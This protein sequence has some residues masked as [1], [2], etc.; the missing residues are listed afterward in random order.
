MNRMLFLTVMMFFVVGIKDILAQADNCNCNSDEICIGSCVI[1][2]AEGY[3]CSRCMK[4]TSAGKKITVG[5]AGA[6]VQ[7]S[8][9]AITTTVQDS[10]RRLQ[11][12]IAQATR[13]NNAT[14]GTIAKFKHDY[15]EG[16][17][18]WKSARYVGGGN[19]LPGLCRIGLLM[20]FIL[21]VMQLMLDF[22]TMVLGQ[23]TH[24][25]KILQKNLAKVLLLAILL[26]PPIYTAIVNLVASVSDSIANSIQSAAHENL[27]KDI[28]A[29]A[30]AMVADKGVSFWKMAES[31]VTY[32]ISGTVFILNLVL[33]MVFPLLQSLIFALAFYLGP[34]CLP[35]MM[36]D[37][38]SNIAKSWFSFLLTVSFMSVI[39]SL[40]ILV[41]QSANLAGAAATG[42]Q[43][44][45]VIAMIIY[46]GLSVVLLLMCYPISTAIFGAGGGGG[47]VGGIMSGSAL[48]TGA[49]VAFTGGAALAARGGGAATTLAGKAASGLGASGLGSALQK[50]G[51]AMS[52]Y[53]QGATNAFVNEMKKS[54][55]RGDPKGPSA[56]DLANPLNVPLWGGKPTTPGNQGSSGNAQSSTASSASNTGAK[57][58][59]SGGDGSS[60]SPSPAPGGGSTPGGS[61]SSGSQS[62]NN[63]NP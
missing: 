51:S 22:V 5:G 14:M 9:T 53:G 18:M 44:T 62:T 24:P 29:I 7:D 12:S 54:V 16:N 47:G 4:D 2:G 26:T 37:G 30:E 36:F 23:G 50:G 32:V 49:A 25:I 39:G 35:F 15:I 11:D 17:N 21:V 48:A 56:G 3:S 52:K 27:M 60:S 59:G 31:L 63:N 34:L 46:G 42:A 38:T 8:A 58:S 20:G 1:V 40:A 6:D 19:A 10:I 28:D 13:N 41:G 43:N 45:S 33:L 61:G 57:S 55:G